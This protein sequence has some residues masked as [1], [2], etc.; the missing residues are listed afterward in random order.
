[1]LV[2]HS[3]LIRQNEFIAHRNLFLLFA[4]HTSRRE[5]SIN[6]G[7]KVSWRLAAQE[8]F[9]QK[10]IFILCTCVAE[11]NSALIKFHVEAWFDDRTVTFIDCL[12]VLRAWTCINHFSVTFNSNSH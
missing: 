1:M 3:S 11:R 4:E 9:D 12:V 2:T 8:A 10:F 6:I 7:A 5:M